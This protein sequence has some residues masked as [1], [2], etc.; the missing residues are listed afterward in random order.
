MIFLTRSRFRNLQALVCCFISVLFLQCGKP[1]Q[2]NEMVS[3]KT[4]IHFTNEIREIRQTNIMAYEY[5][6]NGGGIAVG[7]INN[8]GLPDIYFSGNSVPNK[9]YIN[10]GAWKFEDITNQSKTAGRTDWRPD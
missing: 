1:K 5:A 3:D 7:D 2:I 10:K 6:Y 4:G 8:D 9:L